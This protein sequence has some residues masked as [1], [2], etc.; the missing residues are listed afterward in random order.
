MKKSMM[1]MVIGLSAMPH[2]AAMLVKVPKKIVTKFSQANMHNKL[3]RDALI[4]KDVE[5][6]DALLKSSENIIIDSRMMMN[7]A[8]L[9][10]M[11]VLDKNGSDTK[12]IIFYG[13]NFLQHAMK[14]L[15]IDEDL[16]P[17]FLG[18][19]LDPNVVDESGNN[20]W[21]KLAGAPYY[22]I[23]KSHMETIKNRARLLHRLGVNVN[24]KNRYGK[25][26]LDTLDHDIFNAKVHGYPEAIEVKQ[27]LRRIIEDIVREEINKA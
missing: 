8:S 23:N 27:E 5:R 22:Q 15:H 6:V 21:H 4:E 26:P 11:L 7:A 17:Y 19:G 3:L 12:N 24:A 14:N 10:M 2:V 20:L 13:D 25:Y 18:K 9:E 16:I 1:L